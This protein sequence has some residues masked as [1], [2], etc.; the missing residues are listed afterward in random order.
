[1]EIKSV[2]P[3]LRQDQKVKESG[4]SSYTLQRY[5]QDII[6]LSPIGI[7]SKSYERRQKIPNTRFVHNKLA[8]M[9]SKDLKRP[10]KLETTSLK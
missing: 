3:K 8:N 7:P 1:M 5:R 6:L 10:R 9:T 2:N 4:W